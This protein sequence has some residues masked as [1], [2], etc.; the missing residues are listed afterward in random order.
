MTKF[1][2]LLHLPLKKFWHASNN[3]FT[4]CINEIKIDVGKLIN[5]GEQ[6]VTTPI[7]ELI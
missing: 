1:K 4:T 2:N 6:L 7:W 5:T 3:R